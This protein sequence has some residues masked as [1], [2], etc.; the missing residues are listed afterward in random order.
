MVGIFA[1]LLDFSEGE[2]MSAADTEKGKKYFRSLTIPLTIFP[3]EYIDIDRMGMFVVSGGVRRAAS[4]RKRKEDRLRQ[5]AGMG[6]T[7]SLRSGI[8]ESGRV[9]AYFAESAVKLKWCISRKSRR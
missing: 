8:E 9:R 7:F 3:A 6:L 4:G 1:F 2:R 5:P